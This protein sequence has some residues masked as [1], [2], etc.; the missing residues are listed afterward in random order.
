MSEPKY[1]ESYLAAFD[2]L[3]EIAARTDETCESLPGGYR[4]RDHADAILAQLSAL[5]S[6]LAALT[7]PPPKRCATLFYCPA[8]PD[9]G[10]AFCRDHRCV[11]PKCEAQRYQCFHLCKGHMP[12]GDDAT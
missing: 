3:H 8:K 12:E 5:E 4:E 2:W 10:S 11:E 6:Q 9:E 7:S 1:T